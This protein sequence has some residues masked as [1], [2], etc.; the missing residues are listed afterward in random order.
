MEMNKNNQKS[1]QEEAF[2][3]LKSLPPYN[4]KGDKSQIIDMTTAK[5][6]TDE[7]RS[8]TDPF[9]IPISWNMDIGAL[10]NLLGI[11]SYQGQ[12]AISGI[13]F[14]TG[15]N[16]NNQLTLIAVTTTDNTDGTDDLTVDDNYPYYDYANPCPNNCSNTGNLKAS[17]IDSSTLIFSRTQ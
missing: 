13:R 2:L 14:Y 3:Y 7:F 15:I 5:T 16:E 9:T 12:S 8:I 17:N 11:T 1:A 6:F 10:I 4:H